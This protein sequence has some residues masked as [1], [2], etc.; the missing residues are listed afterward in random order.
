MID[1]NQK[2]PTLTEQRAILHPNE[3]HALESFETRTARNLTRRANTDSSRPSRAR[4]IGAVVAVAAGIAGSVPLIGKAIDYE[5]KSGE[6]PKYLKSK[7]DS[8]G[9]VTYTPE[10][11]AQNR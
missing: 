6:P 7:V 2:S 1:T 10:N 11:L 5:I 9:M 3:F 4:K 8:R